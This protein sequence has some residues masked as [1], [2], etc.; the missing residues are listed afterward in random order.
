MACLV[1]DAGSFEF[2][3]QSDSILGCS[4]LRVAQMASKNSMLQSKTCAASHNTCA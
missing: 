4:H 3:D 1:V 2:V